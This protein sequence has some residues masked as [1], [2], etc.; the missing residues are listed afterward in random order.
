MRAIIRKY[1]DKARD[2]NRYQVLWASNR[3]VILDTAHGG[4]L[5]NFLIGLVGNGPIEFTSEDEVTGWPPEK[6]S[7]SN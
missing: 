5:T 6:F 2:E 4:D 7:S 1:R 3:K